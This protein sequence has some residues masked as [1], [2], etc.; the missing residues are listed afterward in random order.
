MKIIEQSVQLVD[1]INQGTILNKIELCGRV[2]YQSQPKGDPASFVRM[3]IK[4]GH[5]S[6]LE[7][8]SLTFHIIC[9]RAS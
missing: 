2:C 9:D 7:H 6:V 5:E 1:S 3:L 4:R 8:A